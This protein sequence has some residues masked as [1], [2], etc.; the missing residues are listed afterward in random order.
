MINR[1]SLRHVPFKRNIY[2]HICSSFSQQ[3]ALKACDTQGLAGDDT[4][5]ELTFLLEAG[6]ESIQDQVLLTEDPQGLAGDV[7][8]INLL[9]S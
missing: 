5:L 2:L 1:S 9:F 3:R 8:Y 6:W 7:G 4:G